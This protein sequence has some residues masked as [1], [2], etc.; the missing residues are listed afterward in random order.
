MRSLTAILVVALTGLLALATWPTP[1]LVTPVVAP[2]AAP[3]PVS[4]E[5]T[6]PAPKP[7]LA[8]IRRQARN[9]AKPHLDSAD[10]EC[11]VA[12]DKRIQ[13]LDRYFGEVKKKTPAFAEDVLAWGSKWRLVADKLPFTR[14]DRHDQFLREKFAERLFTRKDLEAE[15]RGVV[16]LFLQDVRAIENQMLARIREDLDDLP[17]A[18]LAAQLDQKT[19]DRFFQEA[20]EKTADHAGANLRDA[21]V[22][23]IVSMVVGEAVA[24]AAV[25]L[26]V[27]AGILTAGGASGTV[28]FGVGL[29]V[30][31]IV[32]QIITWVWDWW[33]DPAGALSSALNDKMD[34]L[35][36]ALVEGSSASPGMRPRLQHFARERA[37]ARRTTVLDLIQKQGDSR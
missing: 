24:F 28:T 9:R 37:A 5:T 8:E 3:F 18:L 6:V 33:S 36:L 32:D 12:L 34:E 23:E 29:V 4:I 17:P 31:L 10:R 16:R 14:T 21:I 27:S 22:Q 11:Q 35:R 19:F 30:G 15:L 7:D 20:M 13:G 2:P 26:G 25:R 1:R